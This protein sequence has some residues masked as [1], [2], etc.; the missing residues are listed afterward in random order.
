MKYE[1]KLRYERKVTR[2]DKR[3]R[4]WKTVRED[5]RRKYEPHEKLENLR[6]NEKKKK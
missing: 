6:K 2:E 4:A 3:R 5:L 1:E